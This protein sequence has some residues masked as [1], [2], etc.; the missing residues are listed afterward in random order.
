MA[1]IELIATATFGLEAVVAREVQK[2]GYED[3]KVENARVN[4]KAGTEAICRT[5]LWLRSADRVL[6]KI[7]EFPATT[8]E[9]LFEKT[10]A[11]PW[12]DWIPEDGNFPVEGKSVKSTLYS[13]PDCQAIVKKAVVESMKTRYRRQ[14]FDEKGPRYTIEVALLKDM[15]TLTIDTS[16]PGLHKRGYRKL[17]SAAPLK[18]TLAAAMVNLSYWNPDRLLL[19]PFC[20]SG[21]IPIE[22]ALIGLNMAPGLNREFAAEKWPIIPGKFWQTARQEARNLVRDDIKLEIRGTD[23]N[24]EVLS[25]AR[26]HAKE[27][28]V[29]KH[30]HWQQ[31]PLAEVRTKQKY[32]CVICNPP[33]GE[34]LEEQNTVE[35]LYR[36]MGQVFRPLDTWSFYVLTANQGFERLFGRKADK[37]RKLYNGR[38]ECHYYQYYGPRPPRREE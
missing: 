9:E 14:W 17:A 19:D 27:A 35:S 32:G 26:Y 20:G 5:N 13:V 18:E 16:G 31:M 2:L 36:E 29:E 21:T 33:Y 38:I 22:A 6:I 23:M 12:A 25:M 37:K 10:K 4:F 11:L 8:F 34:R 15:A 7:G 1:L 30:I 3:V 28:G 24:N